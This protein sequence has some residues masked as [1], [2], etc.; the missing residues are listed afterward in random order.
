MNIIEFNQVKKQMGNFVLDIPKLEI[1]QGYI[2]G[3]IGQNGA[4]KTT[5][6][7][8]I[9]DLLNKDSGE[10]KVCGKSMTKNPHE[11]KNIIGYV[12]E[13]SGY[14]EECSIKDIKNM[15]SPFYTN[16]DEALYS[17]YIKRFDLDINKKVKE[18]SQGQNKQLA[19]VMALARRPKLIV[20]DEPTANLDPIV[21]SY[22]LSVL[23]EHMQDEEV[24]VFYSTHITT[25]LEKASDYIVYIQNGKIVFNESKEFIQ[26]NYYNV[27]G[28]KK[29]LS[30]D[31]RSKLIGC[32]ESK[33]NFEGLTNNYEEAH[34]LFGNEAIYERASIEEIMICME[35]GKY[36]E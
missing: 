33:F 24:S 12:G 3:F 23:M 28:P 25:D 18:L 16:W 27:K 1:K 7:K 36:H 26:E 22:I 14:V 2:T 30:E 9:M 13:P 15:M 17:K 35:R 31:K 21:R 34:K 32:E 10:I 8:L 29:I 19:L 11:L 4:G 20:L 5:T 6:I